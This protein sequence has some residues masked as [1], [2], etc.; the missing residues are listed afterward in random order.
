MKLR[1]KLRRSNPLLSTI[2]YYQDVAKGDYKNS[3]FFNDLS[4]IEGIYE[5]RTSFLLKRLKNKSVLHLGFADAPY[6]RERAQQNE[7]LHQK[8]QPVTKELFGL[9][10]DEAAIKLYRDITK[11]KKN[12]HFD[13]Q[14]PTSKI[15]SSIPSKVDVILLGE[16]LEHLPNP[17]IAINNLAKISKK[18]S[19]QVVI[20]VPN[21]FFVGSFAMALEGFEGVHPDH[22]YYFTPITLKKLLK[23]NGFKKVELS[24]YSGSEV[25][26]LGRPLVHPGLTKNGIIAICD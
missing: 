20:T 3:H 23:D 7:L 25:D 11:D 13:L 6:T 17:G 9:D 4:S 2:Q 26:N 16:I 14:D 1:N 18:T 8:L 22:Y 24:F 15:P 19:G 21:A 10:F 5:D 12:S